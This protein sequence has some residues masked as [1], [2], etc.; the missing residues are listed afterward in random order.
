[1]NERM[2]N[3]TNFMDAETM[4]TDLH[5]PAT[6]PPRHVGKVLKHASRQQVNP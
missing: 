2:D 3:G 5:R 6:N 4:P 1:M